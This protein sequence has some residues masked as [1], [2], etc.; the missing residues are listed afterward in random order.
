MNIRPTE[1]SNKNKR[2]WLPYASYNLWQRVTPPIGKEKYHCDLKQRGFG[3][4][5][6]KEEKVKQLLNQDS[7][8]QRIGILA[9]AGVYEFHKD[10]SLLSHLDGVNK[11]AH[12]LNL[13]K[14]SAT[15]QARVLPIL[16]NYYRK[17][18]LAAKNIL[19]LN[20]GDEGFPEPIA[21]K[22]GDYWFNLYAAIDCIFQEAD[23]RLH[24]LDLKT[25]KSDFDKRQAYVYL[26]ATQYLYPD[27]QAIAS[28]YNLETCQFS[29]TI[30]ATKEALQAVKIELAQISQ[31]H[32][33]DLNNYRYN[34]E[35]FSTIFPPNPGF[36]CNYCPFN[37]IC[38]YSAV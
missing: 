18:I 26:L 9:Q 5:R 13:S 17:P 23:G 24:I 11:V 33:K 14:E 30:T 16:Y 8:P 6:N 2:R 7:D 22:Y 21:I 28:F 12:I 36:A 29:E 37:S 15:V 32:Q 10:I 31:Q 27:K 35:K 3:K 38:E 1:K 20:R 4:A 34:K 25:G 19:Q